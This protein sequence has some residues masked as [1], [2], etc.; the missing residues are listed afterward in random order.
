MAS[1]VSHTR[2]MSNRTTALPTTWPRTNMR[3]HK[4]GLFSP[5][6]SPL[7]LPFAL[8]TAEFISEPASGLAKLFAGW[9]VYSKGGFRFR[10]GLDV[11]RPCVNATLLV[12][13]LL[14][15]VAFCVQ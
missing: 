15:D 3:G 11:L 2:P 4:G 1:A 9:K 13:S 6:P 10:L 12:A 5:S 7:P 14:Q 8:S